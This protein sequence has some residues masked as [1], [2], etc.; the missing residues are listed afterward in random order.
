VRGSCQRTEFD[1]SSVESRFGSRYRDVEAASNVLHRVILSDERVSDRSKLRWES[2][3]RQHE[4][5]AL[6]LLPIKKLG[7]WTRILEILFHGLA[8]VGGV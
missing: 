2:L 7:T 5:L 6:L 8:I 1:S 3:D 4:L